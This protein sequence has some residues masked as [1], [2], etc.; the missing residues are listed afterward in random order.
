MEFRK[1]LLPPILDSALVVRLAVLADGIDGAAPGMWESDLAEFTRLSG[2]T[3]PFEH[4][5][6]V[7][8]GDGPENFVRRILF[9][10]HLETPPFVSMEE[11]VEIVS[12]IM[13]CG[14]DHDFYLELF[15]AHCK[16][17]AGTDLIMWPDLV[18]ELP[19]DRLPSA[20]EIAELA[21]RV[22]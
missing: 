17:P 3:I 9:R 16:H 6:G 12:W 14:P 18:P 1:D 7:C 5:Q 13:R 11:F 4:F 15:L 22:Q 10:K 8:A 20:E 2:V 19:Q 21:M